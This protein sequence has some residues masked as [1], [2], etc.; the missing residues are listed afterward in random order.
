MTNLKDASQTNLSQPDPQNTQPSS[1]TE[2]TALQNDD[3]TVTSSQPRGM[4]LRIQ[5]A[6]AIIPTVLGSLAIAGG[7]GWWEVHQNIQKGYRDRLENQSLLASEATRQV[8]SDIQQIQESIASNPLVISTARQASNQI[9]QQEE[10]LTSV[11]ISEVEQRYSETKLLN[12]NQVLN[13]YLKELA[14]SNRVT[15][16]FITEKNG[17]NIAYNQPTSDFVQSDE[18]WWQ[19]GK[20]QGKWL[21][22]LESDESTG[23]AQIDSVNAITDPE[24]GEFLGIIKMEIPASM[25]QNVERYVKHSGILETGQVQIVEPDTSEVF[26]TVTSQGVSERQQI[27]GGEAVE[28]IAQEIT[29]SLQTQEAD[30]ASK[31]AQLEQQYNL[32]IESSEISQ[33]GQRQIRVS[34]RY[35]GRNYEMTT[36][37]KTDWVAISSVDHQVLASAGNELLPAFALTGILLGGTAVG[38]AF[39]LGNYLATP[40]TQVA[41]A[42]QKSAEGD[43]SARAPFKQGSKETQVLAKSYNNLVERVQ[44]LLKE[45]EETAEQ[46]RKQREELEQEVSQLV[47]D[48]EGAS[49]GDLTVR[50]QLMPGDIGI[51]GDL[52][53][54]VVENLQDTAQQVKQ[55]A[56]EVNRSL[57][58]NESSIRELSEGAIAEAEEIQSTLSSISEINNSIQEVAQNAQQAAD[59]ADNAYNTA[60]EGNNTMDQTV[61]NIQQ[62]RST[63]AETS[64]KMKQMGESAQKISQVVSLIDE[65][66]LKT[67]LLAI[68]A[69]VEANRAGEV[70]QG[71]TA[72][73][74]QV[75]S[76]AEQSASAAQEISQIVT[77]IQNETQ[78][79]IEAMEQGTTEVV[80]STRSVEQTKE[81][82]ANVVEQ[83][84]VINNLMQSISQSTV[85]QAETSQQVSQLMEQL[86]QSSQQRS[87][88]S[89]EV[90]ETIQETAQ[91][92]KNLEES[93]ERFK[94]D[95]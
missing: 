12:P 86:A 23:A 29:T 75:E 65:I 25:F 2:N 32:K 55:A 8:L 58:E 64:K 61:A 52:F 45:Q 59:I 69:S 30:L 57:G 73:A 16:I 89:K 78:E 31:I 77:N 19:K 7:Y 22:Q 84:A 10:N 15:E 51:V 36:V 83:S 5:L 87:E 21:G 37:S 43:L 44:Q 41:E 88:T 28:A 50:A 90:A 95:Q 1:S 63:V 13:D 81:Q 70:G 9:Q 3:Q 40:L 71:F 27:K 54:A 53:N 24:S 38:V 26:V 4:A 82:L 11:P 85:S 35:Q 91:V 46:Q 6:W 56:S 33:T 92:A 93:V 17:F 49:E 34:F 68:N 42:A 14:G 79:A 80:E 74:E 60:Q 72:V 76:L 39:L 67:S 62:L 66:S 48:I 94:V 20:Q 18:K 47:D